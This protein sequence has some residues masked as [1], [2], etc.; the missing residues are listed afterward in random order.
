MVCEC[1]CVFV[2][3]QS[4]AKHM[5]YPLKHNMLMVTPKSYFCQAQQIRAIQGDPDRVGIMKLKRYVNE[6]KASQK[7]APEVS[8]DPTI[9]D[10]NSVA[11]KSRQGKEEENKNKRNVNNRA[12]R[13]EN[14]TGYMQANT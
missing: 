5:W 14:D 11:M 12:K 4:I 9:A 3:S 8:L 6:T 7:V 2:S 10:K 1:E 13:I